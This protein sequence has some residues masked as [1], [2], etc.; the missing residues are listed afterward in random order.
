MPPTGVCHLFLLIFGMSVDEQVFDL[1]GTYYELGRAQGART[2]RFGIPAWWPAPPPLAFAL[3]CAR[4]IAEIHAPLLDELHGYADAQG[5]AY[6]DVLRGVCR[7][8]MRAR[9]R[10]APP[11][12]TP[13]YPEGGCSSFAVV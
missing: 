6:D 1:A 13:T 2:E 8:S 9:A 10:A 3:D 12:R 4:Q 11:L 5:L 7:Q